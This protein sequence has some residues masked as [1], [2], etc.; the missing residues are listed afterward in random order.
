MKADNQ[1]L[2]SGIEGIAVAP[3]DLSDRLLID[4]MSVEASTPVRGV[5]LDM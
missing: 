1:A 3:G 4:P 2:T 5:R